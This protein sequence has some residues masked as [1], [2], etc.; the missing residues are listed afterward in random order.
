METDMII[1]I[2]DNNIICLYQTD[3]TDT[4]R[5]SKETFIG[6]LTNTST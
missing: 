3:S 5:F 6:N 2:N 1:V 4:I